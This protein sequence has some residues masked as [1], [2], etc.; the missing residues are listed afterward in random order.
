MR[1][2][3]IIL[4][5][6]VALGGYGGAAG[7]AAQAETGTT[8]LVG[9]TSLDDIYKKLDE[10]AQRRQGGG[11]EHIERQLDQVLKNQAAILAELDV[12]KIRVSRR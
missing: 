8:V 2:A 5:L 12:I 6:L 11:A 9:Q 10:I 1:R 4:S 7:R 3:V